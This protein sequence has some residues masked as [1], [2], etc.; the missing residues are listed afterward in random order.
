MRLAAIKDH[1]T[2]VYGAMIRALDRGVGEVMA[3]LKAQGL[4]R[5]TLV[6]FTNDNGGA[7]YAGLPEHQQAISRLEGDLLRRR[8]S[9]AVLRPM[10]GADRARQRLSM[11][12]QFI[13]TSFRH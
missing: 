6:I 1:R 12:V 8:H 10:A 3:T 2:R 5:N 7:W 13:S 4:D 11:P 9:R